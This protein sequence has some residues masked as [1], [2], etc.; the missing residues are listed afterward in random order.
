M[1]AFWLGTFP[2]PGRI[3]AIAEMAEAHGWDGL[4]FTDSQNLGGDTFA[5]LA[6]A[7]H[8]TERITLAT[9]ATN[10]ATRHPAVIASA[11]ATLQ[12]ESRGRAFLGIARGD[13]AMA[14]IGRK[15]LPLN[16]FEEALTQIQ[17][18]LRGEA[19]ELDGFSSQIEWI[20]QAAQPRV[21]MS[22][23]ATG[24]KVIQLAARVADAITFSVGADPERLKASID[25]AKQ[26]RLNVGLPP[27]S[28]GAYVNAVAHPDVEVARSLVRGRMGVY[29]RFSTMDK[30]VLNSLNEA[31]RKVGEALVASYDIKSHAASGARHEAALADDFVDRFG[32]VGPSDHVAERLAELIQ[33]GLDHV[34][35]VGHSRNTPADVFAESSWRFC[36][37]VIP[38][39]KRALP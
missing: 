2:I 23:A 31:D 4:A 38:S 35:V 3:R 13:S 7:A 21:R 28:F 12:V 22:V 18:Y 6:I 39:V 9:G 26:T 1:L 10:P 8:A 14:Y 29:A 33:L 36:N 16:Q 11:M 5:A 32:I 34:V 37:E 15:P 19:V 17:T 30:T 27:M 20:S 24:P 25:L